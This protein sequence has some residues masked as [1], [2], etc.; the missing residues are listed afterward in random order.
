MKNQFYGKIVNISS[1]AGTSGIGGG[2]HSAHGAAK[3]GLIGF[4][5]NLAIEVA[6]FN[7]NVNSIAPGTIE[8]DGFSR[9][10]YKRVVNHIPLKKIGKPADVAKAVVFL[11]S[12]DSDFITGITLI[13]DGGHSS[14]VRYS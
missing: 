9:E 3:S 12:S 2:W 10:Y 6:E 7:V 11:S 14:I 4:T 1:I 8:T 13:V 5:K